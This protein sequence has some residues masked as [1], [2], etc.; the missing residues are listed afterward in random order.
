MKS[1]GYLA[2]VNPCS[3]GHI[4]PQSSSSSDQE[5]SVNKDQQQ[6]QQQHD[7]HVTNCQQD[8][9][10]QHDVSS[11]QTDH[12]LEDEEAS[13]DSNDNG[14]HNNKTKSSKL[15][16]SLTLHERKKSK[17]LKYNSREQIPAN[18]GPDSRFIVEA[19]F[20]PLVPKSNSIQV[21]KLID[22]GRVTQA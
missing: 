5:S 9:Q 11:C 21:I 17:T 6:Q 19:V 13:D 7:E 10:Q 8:Q 20:K 4:G 18:R 3:G 15:K 1:G 2:L 16:R 14:I 22:Q 12:V